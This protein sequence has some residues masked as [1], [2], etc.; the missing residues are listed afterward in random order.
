LKRDDRSSIITRYVHTGFIK[1]ILV[2]VVFALKLAS[3]PAR[4]TYDSN[5]FAGWT[6]NAAARW[7]QT[8]MS[9]LKS[10]C[11]NV[12]CTKSSGLDGIANTTIKRIG[13]PIRAVIGWIHLGTVLRK[14]IYAPK[15]LEVLNKEVFLHN[16]RLTNR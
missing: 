14:N 13:V 5:G 1:M 6:M 3:F 12:I 16:K 10:D 11:H 8:G 15:V 9:H 4:F 7:N 2:P